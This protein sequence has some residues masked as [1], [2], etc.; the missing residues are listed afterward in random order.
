[1]K[2]ISMTPKL[3][4][5]VDMARALTPGEQLELLNVLADLIQQNSLLE[6]QSQEFWQTPTLQTLLDQQQPPIVYGLEPL[7]IDFWAEEE[8][9]EEFLNFL[10]QQRHKNALE[11]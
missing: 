1:V 5:T 7:R 2:E 6:A 10:Y 3:Q 4:Q 11:A 8:P 9:E